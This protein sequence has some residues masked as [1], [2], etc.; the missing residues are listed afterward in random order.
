MSLVPA[1]QGLQYPDHSMTPFPLPTYSTCLSN[2]WPIT[3]WRQRSCP[4]DSTDISC[5]NRV[6][7]KKALHKHLLQKQEKEIAQHTRM[8]NLGSCKRLF[9]SNQSRKQIKARGFWPCLDCLGTLAHTP[10]LHG[11]GYSSKSVCFSLLFLA[12][13]IT[14]LWYVCGRVT[15]VPC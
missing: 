3:L 10:I 7:H 5:S 4:S 6:W 12:F 13:W 9:H 15:C 14:S 2:C 11:S 8:A 1:C